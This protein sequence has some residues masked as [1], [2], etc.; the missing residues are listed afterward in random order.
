MLL[1]PEICESVRNA[2]SSALTVPEDLIASGMVSRL[3][4]FVF[5]FSNVRDDTIAVL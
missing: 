3:M 1:P 2:S 4:L 5:T